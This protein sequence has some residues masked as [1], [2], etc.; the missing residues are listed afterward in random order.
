M[1]AKYYVRWREDF[2][3]QWGWFTKKELKAEIKRI[4]KLEAEED[5]EA[6]IELII[7]GE[8]KTNEFL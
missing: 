3:D 4:K 7:Q 6:S 1:E 8:D 2:D 5:G